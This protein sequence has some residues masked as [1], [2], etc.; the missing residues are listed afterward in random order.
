MVNIT[1]RFTVAR[2]AIRRSETGEFNIA[3]IAIFAHP[4][5]L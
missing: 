3:I 1:I 4:L 2:I 5:P